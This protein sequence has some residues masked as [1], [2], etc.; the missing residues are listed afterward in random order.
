[1]INKITTLD[2]FFEK[3]YTEKE[4]IDKGFQKII[5]KIFIIN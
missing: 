5:K 3:P 4:L 1:M 2:L